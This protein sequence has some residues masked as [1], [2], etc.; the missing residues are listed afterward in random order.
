MD[1]IINSRYVKG[2]TMKRIILGIVV[3]SLLL[4]T[5]A[6]NS[7]LNSDNVPNSS[8]SISSSEENSTVHYEVGDVDIEKL[9][10]LY[11]EFFDQDKSP[12]KGIEIYVWQMSA[13]SYSFG[14]MYGTNRNKTDEEIWDLQNKSLTLEETK[15]ILNECGVTKDEFF[16]I[17]VIQ[18]FSSYA[19][20]IDDGYQDRVSKLFE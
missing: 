16:I 5:T 19:Y 10:G 18:P 2:E 1:Q 14:L 20:T 7:R 13:G 17:P 15:A 4:S 3:V 12:A 6:C 9:K 8:E 11:P